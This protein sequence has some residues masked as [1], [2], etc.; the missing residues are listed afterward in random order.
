MGEYI[1]D[2]FDRILTKRLAS[3]ADCYNCSKRCYTGLIRYFQR[4][5]TSVAIAKTQWKG[6]SSIWK[7]PASSADTH[8]CEFGS[9]TAIF[10]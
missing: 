6:Y 8:S 5:Q 3:S 4:F 1:K 9:H 10:E 7:P 2:R